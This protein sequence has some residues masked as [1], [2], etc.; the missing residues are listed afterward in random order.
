MVIRF[1]KF[2]LIVLLLI[3]SLPP[4]GPAAIAQSLDGTELCQSSN[5]QQRLGVRCLQVTPL[6]SSI[7]TYSTPVFSTQTSTGVP[8]VSQ[9]ALQK[10]G[11]EEIEIPVSV[12][13]VSFSTSENLSTSTTEELHVASSGLVSSQQANNALSHSLGEVTNGVELTSSPQVSH[14]GL[15]SRNPNLSDSD[16]VP[17]ADLPEHFLQSQA[18]DPVEL[19]LPSSN[20]EDIVM[21]S[22]V[23]PTSMHPVIS[24]SQVVVSINDVTMATFS[25][26]DSL[27]IMGQDGEECVIVEEGCQ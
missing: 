27:M 20:S 24:A 18:D 6:S 17:Q 16:L 14:H 5:S 13:H 21:S 7:T 1:K 12:N 10:E 22:G 9:Q 26:S 19:S 8:D 4:E 23:S 11:N 3:S 15:T 2:S 25:S